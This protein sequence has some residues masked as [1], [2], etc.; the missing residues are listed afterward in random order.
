MLPRM[1]L[2]VLCHYN[3]VAIVY[4]AWQAASATLHAALH[5]I[6]QAGPSVN[7]AAMSH[8]PTKQMFPA[9][10]KLQTTVIASLSEALQQQSIPVP[11]RNVANSC[12]NPEPPDKSYF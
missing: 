8:L 4:K 7:Q 12:D 1:A 5:Q 11:H 9:L 6:H 2:L 10:R 3:N